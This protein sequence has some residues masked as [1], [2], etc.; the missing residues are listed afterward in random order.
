MVAAPRPV[1]HACRAAAREK[2]A[3]QDEHGRALDHRHLVACASASRTPSSARRDHHAACLPRREAPR[4]GRAESAPGRL[5]E[6]TRGG[7]SRR[8]VREVEGPE[9]HGQARDARRSSAACTASSG[10]RC[11]GRIAGRWP[12]GAHGIAARSSG[13]QARSDLGEAA[14]SSRCRPRGRSGASAFPR[15]PA[16]P[17]API[18]IGVAASGEMLGGHA[19]APR[20]PGDP[21]SSHSVQPP[22]PLLPPRA[23]RRLLPR[24]TTMRR[25][26]RAMSARS[27]WQSA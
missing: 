14:R 26:A 19:V 1:G 23:R 18:A 13:P 25:A 4:P 17:R 20:T 9:V 5:G 8:L 7:S 16:R 22:S 24:G 10:S 15:R 2:D 21:M 11:T 6:E 12:I 3:G 27:G